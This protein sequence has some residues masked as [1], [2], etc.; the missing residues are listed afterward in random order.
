MIVA[1]KLN[2]TLHAVKFDDLEDATEMIDGH[3][4][5]GNTL[6]ITN[7]IDDLDVFIDYIDIVEVVEEK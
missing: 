5:A 6:V 2:K 7:D 1:V 4:E 3:I